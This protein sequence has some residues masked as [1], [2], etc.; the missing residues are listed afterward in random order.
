[1]ESAPGN[2]HAFGMS[3]YDIFAVECFLAWHEILMST[4]IYLLKQAKMKI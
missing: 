4:V 2:A 1:M 3:V